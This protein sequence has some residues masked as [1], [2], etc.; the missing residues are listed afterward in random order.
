MGSSAGNWPAAHQGTCPMTTPK[1]SPIHKLDDA[2]A[3]AWLRAQ[4]G[5]TV[6]ATAAELSRRW[7]WNDRQKAGRRLHAWAKAGLITCRGDTVTVVTPSVTLPNPPAAPSSAPEVS[8]TAT[9]PSA[10]T[11]P[12]T[13][14]VTRGVDAAAYFVA[15]ALAGIAAVFS[16]RGMVVLF[17]GAPSLVIA[18]AATMEAAKLVT[19]A[20][21]S[22]RWSVTPWIARFVL[23]VFI[24]GIAAINAVGVF[25]QL[26][27]AHVG[28]R[29]AAQATMEM[30]DAALVAKL[31][32][33]AGR[34][35]D[36]DRR[37]G[38]IDSA[39]EEA[40]KRGR[41]TTAL[42]AMEGQRQTRASLAGEREKAAG[43]LAALKAERAGVA[44]KA[45]QE[46]TEAAPIRYVAEL[47]GAATDPEQAIRLLIL[48]MVL[49]CDPLAIALTA[50]ASAHRQ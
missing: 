22:A 25:S 23:M 4:P 39:I 24:A 1:I 11:P 17:P 38:Q 43:T 14:H 37:L 21:L 33:A 2:G 31:E 8:A 36:L 45:K 32:V 16:I 26:V 44:S 30:A 28:E 34:L 6:T 35:A 7:G 27:S 15:T 12:V 50:V 40:T 10:V 42:A 13:P 29:G 19:T 18:M 20:L 5:G 41:T 46:E 3:L 48:L 9:V 47:A 49:C